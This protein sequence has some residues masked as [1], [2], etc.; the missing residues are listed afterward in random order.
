M[1]PEVSLP[2]WQESATGPYPQRHD[3][4]PHTYILLSHDPL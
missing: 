1:E 3:S 4:S 2:S